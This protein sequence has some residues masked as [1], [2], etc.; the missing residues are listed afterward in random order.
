MVET[1]A[2]FGCEVADDVVI[3]TRGT[4]NGDVLDAATVTPNDLRTLAWS[5]A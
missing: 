3:F 1:I 4:T 2:A 5:A